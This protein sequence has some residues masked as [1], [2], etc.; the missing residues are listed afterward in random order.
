M[1]LREKMAEFKD[2]ANDVVGQASQCA[3]ES[4]AITNKT[5][6]KKEVASW[7]RENGDETTSMTES[8]SDEAEGRAPEASPF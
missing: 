3:G 1:P 5:E 8:E 4:L 6:V 2:Q 7:V